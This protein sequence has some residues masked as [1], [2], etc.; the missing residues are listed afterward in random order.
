MYKFSIII[1]IYNVEK[2]LTDCLDSLLCQDIS[3][4]EYEIICVNDGSQ[5]NSAEIVRRYMEQHINIKLIEQDNSGVCKARNKG[6]EVAT[7]FYVWFVDSD[8][9]VA[10]NCLGKIYNEMQKSQADI[11]E[12]DYRICEENYKFKPETVHFKINGK[13]KP[14]SSGSGCMSVCRRDYLIEN[15]IVFNPE[16][17]YGEDYLWA[18][19]TKYRKHV[20]I[21]TNSALYIYRQHRGSAMH[22]VDP[23]KTKKH[24]DDMMK[25]FSIY[26]T[27]YQR[28]EAEGMREKILKNIRMRQQLC[29]ESAM[30]CLMKLKL[31]KYEFEEQLDRIQE[32]EIYPYRFMTWNLL[33]KGTV[34]PLKVRL[35]TFLFPIKVYYKLVCWVYRSITR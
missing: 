4:D 35:F 19:Q 11:F 29:A 26:E 16:L 15:K 30:L 6:F 22:T 18:F 3:E 12:F 28:C 23:I 5:D 31:P 20:S 8:D 17:S 34:N 13:N 9:I 14:G 33:G 21:Y 1:P 25:L 32:K 7:G 27:E 10:S 2:F 24:M